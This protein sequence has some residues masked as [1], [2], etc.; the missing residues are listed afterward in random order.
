MAEK[1]NLSIE[2]TISRLLDEER[3]VDCCLKTIEVPEG[4][5]MWVASVPTRAHIYT[6]YNATW[7]KLDAGTSLT[8]KD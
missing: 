2:Q 5:Q 7:A 3:M 1:R 6:G 8:S 4:D